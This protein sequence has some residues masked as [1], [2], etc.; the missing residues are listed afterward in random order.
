MILP[1]AKLEGW[2]TL[3]I[4]V[5]TDPVVIVFDPDYYNSEGTGQNIRFLSVR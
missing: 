1:G 2:V 5:G 4:P 3:S